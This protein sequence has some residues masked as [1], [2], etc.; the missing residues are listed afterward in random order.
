MAAL[1]VVIASALVSVTVLWQQAN[2]ER[3]R[4]QR[5][6]SDAR[7]Q[8]QQAEEQR[9]VAEE[10]RRLAENSERDAKKQKEAA[11]EQR[12]RA[13]ASADKA[14][15]VSVFLGGIFEAAD[16]IGLS[17][18]GSVIPKVTGESLTVRELLNRGAAQ[19]EADKSL[20]PESRAFLLDRIGNA[21]LHLG[22]VDR[23]NQMLTRAYE[24]RRQLLGPEHSETVATLHNLAHL[25]HVR[26]D[27]FKAEELYRKALAARLRQTPL[28]ERELADTEFNLGWLLTEMEDYEPA[29]A[30]LRL[31]LER[32]IRILGSTHREV[33]ATHLGLAGV[34]IEQEDYLKAAAEA[35]E[36]R[37]VLLAQE[38]TGRLAHAA[39]L[40]QD[41]VVSESLT[42]NYADAEKKL[43]EC[44]AI[45]EKQLDPRH[46]YVALIHYQLGSTQQKLKKFDEAEKH[47]RTCLDVLR[48]QV[49]LTHAKASIPMAQLTGLLLERGKT[50]DAAKLFDDWLAAHRAKPGPFL[51]D[52]L[53]LYANFLYEQGEEK[54]ERDT[55][56]EALKIYR[57][58]PRTPRRFR[59]LHCL[60]DLS[61]NYY[62]GGR[63]A[64]ADRL[65][66]ENVQLVRQRFGERSTGAA[67][68]LSQFATMRLARRKAEDDVET[69]LKD[70]RSILTPV[71]PLAPSPPL[72]LDV[73]MSLSCLYRLRDKPTEAARS[74]RAARALMKDAEEF[75]AV[76]QEFAWCSSDVSRVNPK[77][78][79]EQMEESRRFAEEAVAALRQ[80]AAKGFKDAARLKKEDAFAPLRSRADYQQLLRD[81]DKPMPK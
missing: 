9:K 48:S 69:A 73:H 18:Y 13:L 43:Q 41:A 3:D 50:A 63:L 46:I 67:I 12:V 45:M 33:G 75:Y 57:A 74:A 70:A 29:A 81:L 51:A 8:Q 62:R 78:S 55:L 5:N 2:G 35:K 28:A 80:A 11:E 1:V 59:Y 49:G 44:L 38:G 42:K 71:L 39:T 34:Y 32:K 31:A 30:L 76:A 4:A 52:A 53:T 66:T 58:E 79:A 16:P 61:W 27:Y 23:A 60:R 20:A 40:F 72:L 36:A 14:Q 47:Y 24:M 6:E 15:R 25:A 54:R 21:Y 17:G 68:A 19:L 64:D 77:P 22:D 37:T 65:A 10:Q 7:S 26:G 56:E